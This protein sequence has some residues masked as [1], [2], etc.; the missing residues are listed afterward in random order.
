[1]NKT[2]L[3][4]LLNIEYPIIQAPMDWITNANL[5]AAV[6]NAGGLGVLGPNAGS[7]TVTKDV[8]ETGERLRLEIKKVKSL[9]DKP[10]GVNL[11]AIQLPVGFPEG[12]KLYSDQCCSVIL[13]EKVPVVVLC[14]NT[15]EMYVRQLKEGG[16]TVLHRGIPVDVEIAKKAE[17]AGIDA[18]VA[19]GYEGGG[20]AGT[21]NPTSVLVPQIV[22]A[23]RVPVV[24]GGGIADGRGL[25]AALSWGATGAYIGTRFIATYECPAHENVKQAIIESNDV[26]TV[27]LWGVIGPLRALRTP[28]T[29]KCVEM[30]EEGCSLRA[31]AE[32]YHEGYI[33]GML[34]GD[35]N[36]GTFA[37][38]SACGLINE[39][40]SAGEVVKTIMEEADQI[41]TSM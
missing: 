34:E 27:S 17:M 20:H 10:F 24:A 37:C 26:S 14:G 8:V 30:E 5:V 38:G 28:I 6:S 41:V 7:R 2:K 11:I 31:I 1:M 40:K 19:V 29:R 13:E 35:E 4:S 3:C 33:K 22:D 15:P 16:V 9:A 25:V 36:E 12:G 21:K 23:L 18:Y 39:V 32:T